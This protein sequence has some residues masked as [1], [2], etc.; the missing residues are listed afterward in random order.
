MLTVNTSNLASHITTN[1]GHILFMILDEVRDFIFVKDNRCRFIYN[2][3]AHLEHLACSQ[4]DILGRTDFDIF[5][6][7]LAD[8]FYFDEKRLLDTRV[9]IIKVQES[10]NSRGEMFFTTALKQLVCSPR[11]EILGFFGI[12]RRL[13]ANDRSGLEKTHRDILEALRRDPGTTPQQ[14]RA[15]ETSLPMLLSRTTDGDATR[16]PVASSGSTP[17]LATASPETLEKP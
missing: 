14:L 4:E 9:P 1:R 6:K 8:S 7:A 10:V 5:P 2:N 3:R 16:V 11:G 13:L 12:I 15:F 17:P